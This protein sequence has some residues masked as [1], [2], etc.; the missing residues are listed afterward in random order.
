MRHIKV[1]GFAA[2]AALSLGTFARAWITAAWSTRNLMDQSTLVVVAKPISS[3]VMTAK[4]ILPN[5]TSGLADPNIYV[6]DVATT[7][8]VIAVVK[9]VADGGRVV[10]HHLR[11]T[12][13]RTPAIA[14]PGLAD[15]E[16]GSGKRYRMFLKRESNGYYI[17]V[18]GLLD[19]WP[20]IVGVN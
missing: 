20:A 17:C 18:S 8:E 15:F 9:G 19:P 2:V 13:G 12:N 7:F 6:D 10:L 4:R 3:K 1:L 5:I 11:Y 14:G 16:L